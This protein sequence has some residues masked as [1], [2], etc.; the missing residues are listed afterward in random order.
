MLALGQPNRKVTTSE[1]EVIS[2]SLKT[3]MCFIYVKFILKNLFHGL[4]DIETRYYV[5]YRIKD[6][7]IYSVTFEQKLK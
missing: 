3:V 1:H 4:S 5:F 2:C 7:E 6:T